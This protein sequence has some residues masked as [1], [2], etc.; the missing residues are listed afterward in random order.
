MVHERITQQDRLKSMNSDDFL[1]FVEAV[2][3]NVVA[4]P[5]AVEYFKRLY[6]DKILNMPMHTGRLIRE[7]KD[8]IHQYRCMQSE[9]KH[10][11]M[12]CVMAE[13]CD[14]LGMEVP[15][16]IK[17]NV[18]KEVVTGFVSKA[19]HDDSALDS[20][21][22]IQPRNLPD[23]MEELASAGLSPT[24]R[25]K[26]AIDKQR[27][28]AEMYGMRSKMLAPKL[29]VDLAKANK[30]MEDFKKF[31]HR[32]SVGYL[33]STNHCGE[34]FLDTTPKTCSLFSGLPKH[35]EKPMHLTVTRPVMVGTTDI[36]TTSKDNLN[37]I[38]RE[39]QQQIESSSDLQEISQ[40]HRN[41]KA[42]LEEVI[43]LCVEQLDKGLEKK[44]GLVS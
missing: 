28:F 19:K 34:I 3:K 7:S 40:H 26:S 14:L 31:D 9:L 11:T 25:S 44:E 16:Y 22:D 12:R 13:T 1:V 6:K 39:A 38:I 18:P 8:L 36:L 20:M 5:K 41:E 21:F 29:P 4:T 35:K 17:V 23:T 27:R 43:K 37:A 30:L 15:D 32:V 10:H 2:A 42:K 33:S 24:G